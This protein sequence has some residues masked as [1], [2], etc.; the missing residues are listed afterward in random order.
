[1]IDVSMLESMLGLLLSEVQRQ[2]FPLPK[3]PPLYAPLAAADGF[4]MPAI[5]TER[6]FHGLAR[7]A[8]HPEWITDPRFAQYDARRQ[9]WAPCWPN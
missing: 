2:Q 6:T 1:M 8:G 7:A 9:N 3:V 4:I 5:G